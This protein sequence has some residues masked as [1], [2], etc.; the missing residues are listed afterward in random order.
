MLALPKKLVAAVSAGLGLLALGCTDNV[1]GP[2]RQ[3]LARL[4]T[5]RAFAFSQGIEQEILRLE[6]SI[7][8]IGGMYMDGGDM[9]VLVPANTTRERVVSA[10]AQK[11]AGMRITPDIKALL[12]HGDRIRIRPAK[13][14]LSQLIAWEESLMT[15]LSQVA[16]L[17]GLDADESTNQVRVNVSNA[18]Y[19]TAV[20]EVAA[21]AGVPADAVTIKVVPK[22]AA[23]SGLR[24]TWR[25]TGGAIQLNFQYWEVCTLGFNV[26]TSTGLNGLLT[27]GHCARG[28]LGGGR[29]DTYEQVY[30]P[31]NASDAYR[32]GVVNINPAWN[33]QDP[34]C[35]GY[36]LCTL[37]DA[38]FVKYDLASTL[39]KRVAY[40]AFTGL[41][42]Q[43]GSITITGWWDNVVAP[44]ASY[45]VGQ[46]VDKI[47]PQ[48]GW[49]RGTISQTCIN[50]PVQDDFGSYYM[51]VCADAVTGSMV[52]QYDSGSPVFFPPPADLIHNPLTPVGILFAGAPMD[53]FDNNGFPFDDHFCRYNC[54]YYFSH[55][56][57]IQAAFG[58]SLFPN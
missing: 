8:G 53:Q 43:G 31:T 36:S 2:T 46:S 22:A 38:L 37:A 48:T 5:G 26:T 29:G 51:D 3:P 14:A 27:A 39:S 12:L 25:P 18:A 47:G 20:Q 11:A 10:F 24:G 23:L 50:V 33:L 56:S 19:I 45:F 40:T 42:G 57:A 15:P 7:P 34:A 30:Q 28:A 35:G 16:G 32:V 21:A 58:V 44:T 54:T 17:S 55:W 41:N 4:S 13:F 52:G 49:T 1:A 6:P 9:V